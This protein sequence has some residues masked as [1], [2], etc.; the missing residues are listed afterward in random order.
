MKALLIVEYDDEFDVDDLMVDYTLFHQEQK[1]YKMF[2]EILKP[3]PQ[4]KQIFFGSE[5]EIYK[6]IGW[7]DCLREILGEEE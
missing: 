6:N 7:N 4:A 1:V 3:I 2:N 5:S